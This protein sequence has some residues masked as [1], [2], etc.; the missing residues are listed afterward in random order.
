MNG[1]LHLLFQRLVDVLLLMLVIFSVER[2]DGNLSYMDQGYSLWQPIYVTFAFFFIFFFFFSM[3]SSEI[4][5]LV[6]TSTW[7]M[8]GINVDGKTGRALNVEH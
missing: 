8:S 5:I 6:F 1:D 2:S 7:A 4:L 3:V